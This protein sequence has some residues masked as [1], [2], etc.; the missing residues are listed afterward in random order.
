MD[1]LHI[2]FEGFSGSMTTMAKIAV[3]VIPLMVVMQFI[4]ELKVLDKFT[5]VFSPFANLLGISKQ[6][7]LPLLAG[8]FLGISYG[9]G[10][11]IQTAR[12]GLMT[13]RDSYLVIVFLA[14]CH[15]FFEDNFIFIAIGADP[16]VVLLGRLLLALA[17]TIV[18]SRLWKK[19]PEF[20]EPDPTIVD[21]TLRHHK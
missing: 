16:V 1:V 19:E 5:S 2:L 8:F 17:V 9:G 18:I 12:T 14:I 7:F 4:E 13:K 11:I 10:I 15:S 20:M 6:A 3:I 21:L